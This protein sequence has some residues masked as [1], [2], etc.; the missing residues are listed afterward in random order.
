M[1]FFLF[2]DIGDPNV[3]FQPS[4]TSFFT[5]CLKDCGSV[6]SFVIATCLKIVVGLTKD[7]LP[8]KYFC[9]NIFF[10]SVEFH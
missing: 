6:H 1:L 8:V 3:G 5:T 9:S 2:L 4:Q 7:T 10:V